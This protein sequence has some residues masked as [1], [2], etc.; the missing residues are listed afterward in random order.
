MDQPRPSWWSR[1]WKWVVPVGC[2][3]PIV[4]CGGLFG[5]IVFIVNAAIRSSDVY[6]EALT[7]ARASPQVRAAVGEPMKAGYFASGSISDRGQSGK[8][9]LAIP[10]SGPKGTATIYVVAKK[11]DGK[12]VYSRLEAT[13]AIG[14]RIDL[15]K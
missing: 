13:P 3:T 1:N 10:I 15:L 9:D 7:R 5:G 8:A 14:G 12:W 2:A 4:L 11:V 6:A